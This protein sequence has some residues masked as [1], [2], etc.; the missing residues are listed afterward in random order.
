MFCSPSDIL[1]EG[2]EHSIAE[3]SHRKDQNY[4]PYERTKTTYESSFSGLQ[5]PKKRNKDEL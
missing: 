1:I 3:I 2:L 5:H 4:I